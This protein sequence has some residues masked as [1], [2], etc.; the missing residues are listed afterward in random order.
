MVLLELFTVAPGW[1]FMFTAEAVQHE[2]LQGKD[3]LDWQHRAEARFQDLHSDLH[4]GT[5]D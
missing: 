3:A 1:C 2:R 4:P 5:Q